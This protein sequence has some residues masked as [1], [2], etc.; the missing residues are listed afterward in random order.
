MGVP[1][2][3]RTARQRRRSAEAKIEI[4]RLL[5]N[6]KKNQLDVAGFTRCLQEVWRGLD[7]NTIDKLLAR[8]PRRLAAVKKA[9]GWYTKC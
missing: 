6:M 1:Y 2:Q 8:I 3:N 9:R 5:D 7:Q 4:T